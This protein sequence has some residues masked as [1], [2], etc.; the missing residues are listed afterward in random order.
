MD[1]YSFEPAKVPVFDWI[2]EHGHEPN[3]PFWESL[4]NYIQPEL[5]EALDYDVEADFFSVFGPSEAVEE[6]KAA[7]EPLTVDYRKLSRVVESA[8]AEDFEFD[9]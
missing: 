7:L 4:G 9:D 8:K 1:E 6:F 2:I 5:S 3:G